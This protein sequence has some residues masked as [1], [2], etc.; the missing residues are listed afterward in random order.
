MLT[1]NRYLTLFLLCFLFALTNNVCAKEESKAQKA[2]A[3]MQ[4]FFESGNSPEEQGHPC[5]SNQ[6]HTQRNK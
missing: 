2:H 5:F 3:V 4:T 6:D 1:N